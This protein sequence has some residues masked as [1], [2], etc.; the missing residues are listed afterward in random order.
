MVTENKGLRFKNYTVGYSTKRIRTAVTAP[1]S[2][3]IPSGS[4]TCVLGIN[5]AGKSTLLRS[6]AQLQAPLSGQVAFE[7]QS[8]DQLE[9]P[10]LARTLSVVLTDHSYSK[11]LTVGELVA[12]GRQPYTDWLGNLS[13]QDKTI[14]KSALEKTDTLSLSDRYCSALSDGQMQRVLIARA[15]AQDTP[16]LLLDEP[17]THLDLHHKAS[18]LQLLTTISATMGKTVIFSTHDIS[19]V[20][21]ICSHALVLD[22]D[23]CALGTPEQLIEQGVFNRLF[24][25]DAVTFD[26]DTW[27]FQLRK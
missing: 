22:N 23:S 12:L 15:L 7:D 10:E 26:P 5:G 3:Q 19:L 27:A 4:L 24:P 20:L 14:I 8:L 1:L 21:P 11:N 6:V 16:L 9:A 2:L 18:V 17:T 13:D 25:K